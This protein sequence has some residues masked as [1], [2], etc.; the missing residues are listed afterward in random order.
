MFIVSVLGLVFGVTGCA[1]KSSE[2]AKTTTATTTS[3][4]DGTS[5]STTAS[6]EKTSSGKN[7]T[8]DTIKGDLIDT[9][10]K[11]PDGAHLEKIADTATI[12]TIDGNPITMGEY[13]RQF[14][15]QQQQ[16]EASIETKPETESLLLAQAKQRNLTLTAE[17]KNRLLTTAKAAQKAQGGNFKKF[18]E[19]NKMTEKQYDQNI[20]EMGLSAKAANAL[21]QESLLRELVN[22]ELLADAARKAGF[23]QEAVKKFNDLKASEEF[24][25]LRSA[26][27]FSEEDLQKEI[28]K[29]EMTKLMIAKIQK[30]SP[31]SDDDVRKFY[32]EHK[33]QLKHGDRIR[34][35]QIVIAAPKEHIGPVM[36]VK[37]VVLKDNPKLTGAELDKAVADKTAEKKKK[38]EELLNQAK[39]GGDFAKLADE[40]TDDTAM[41]KL[42]NGGDTGWQELGPG[43]LTKELVEALKPLKVGEINPNVIE[44]PYGFHIIKLTG[45]EGP[46]D[47][48]F[49]EIKDKLKP[50]LAQKHDDDV[51]KAWLEKQRKGAKV[52]L[53][54][55]FEAALDLAKKNG[56]SAD[57][58]PSK[59]AIKDPRKK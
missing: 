55:E 22:R 46:G 34:F 59:P 38:A 49:D 11:I 41:Q 54:S 25:R 17:E 28:V 23:T 9:V 27:G 14:K 12:C 47:L 43:R 36:S 42:K 18:L 15:A 16:V 26:T 57:A 31:L 51:V 20:L 44:T 8:D 58:P 40:N 21:I 30:D 45:K 1:Q 35:S 52:L 4:A 24:K 32:D 13:R 19:S 3:T 39:A 33:A 37:D 50:L 10:P 53:A 56:S 5:T 6:A 29:N 48:P 7:V 2:T